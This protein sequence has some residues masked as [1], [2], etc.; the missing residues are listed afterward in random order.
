MEQRRVRQA[1]QAR[2]RLLEPGRSRRHPLIRSLHIITASWRT[3]EI[4]SR[5]SRR[6]PSLSLQ[7][8]RR[9]SVS[10]Y[11]T[12]GKATAKCCRSACKSH[13]KRLQTACNPH[14][15][16]TQTASILPSIC[17]QFSLVSSP[18]TEFQSHLPP[19]KPSVLC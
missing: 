5:S 8:A 14:S 11:Q 2:F 9:K 16:C 7:A 13:A 4:C 15:K 19:Q 6:S 18:C 3:I 17:M 1:D 10:G 12:A